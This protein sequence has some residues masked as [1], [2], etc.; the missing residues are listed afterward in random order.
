[1]NILMTMTYNI[2]C[3]YHCFTLP[4]KLPNYISHYYYHISIKHIIFSIFVRILHN[5][6]LHIYY[7]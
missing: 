4:N 7:K 5:T 2:H 1:M 3:S 6:T